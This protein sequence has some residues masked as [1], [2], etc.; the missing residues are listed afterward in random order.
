MKGNEIMLRAVDD[1]DNLLYYRV[2]AY[3]K[4]DLEAI[5]TYLMNNYPQY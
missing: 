4:K 3:E 5:A 1:N 2:N